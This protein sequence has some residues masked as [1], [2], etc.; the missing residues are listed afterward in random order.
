LKKFRATSSA[1]QSTQAFKL[2]ALVA[3]MKMRIA[4]DKLFDKT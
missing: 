1:I 4:I 2:F 3:I